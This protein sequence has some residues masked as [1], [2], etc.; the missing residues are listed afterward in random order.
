MDDD[1]RAKPTPDKDPE[2][3]KKILTLYQLLT[4][5]RLHNIRQR[6]KAT[7]VKASLE[8]RNQPDASQSESNA[9]LATATPAIVTP[10]IA[11][12]NEIIIEDDNHVNKMPNSKLYFEN[13][14]MRLMLPIPVDSMQ[15]LLMVNIGD[16]F[17]HIWFPTWRKFLSAK[18][19]Q[20]AFTLAEEAGK[21][22]EMS[23]QSNH[24]KVFVTHSHNNCIFI[25]P[26]AKNDKQNVALFVKHDNHMILS[27]E[28]Y[29]T[30]GQTY[31]RK[32]KGK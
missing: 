13:S 4:T 21:A 5:Q 16:D 1:F 14:S 31:N 10:V 32:T 15:R 25:G 3:S 11:K 26:Y 24:P 6:H 17:T 2:L 19:I 30:Y 12:S 29:T 8:P 7:A 28:Y 18:R 27:E 22:I 9:T 23:Q 20:E